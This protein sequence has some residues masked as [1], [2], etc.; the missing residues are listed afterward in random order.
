[1]GCVRE[2]EGA[3]TKPVSFVHRPKIGVRFVCHVSYLT[4]RP[5]IGCW[6]RISRFEIFFARS[7]SFLSVSKSVLEPRSEIFS[8]FRC[9]FPPKSDFLRLGLVQQVSFQN[10]AFG[11]AS[12]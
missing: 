1:M 6:F 5:K 2:G 11:L 9:Y 4:K 8:I 7:Q 3:D 10:V 12:D